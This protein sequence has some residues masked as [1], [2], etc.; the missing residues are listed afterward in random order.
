M[1][2]KDS[3]EFTQI[4]L[5]LPAP[6]SKKNWPTKQDPSKY[7]INSLWLELKLQKTKYE[8]ATYNL[9]EWLGDVGGL[10]DGLNIIF[11]F[12]L[13]PASV[14]S[15]RAEVLS[16][17]FRLSSNTSLSKSKESQQNIIGYSSKPGSK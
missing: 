17:V 4:E 1:G 9:L 3:V 7:K 8:R 16:Q 6:S 15:L 10:F 12:I 14:F 2:Q 11:G 13:W 5:G